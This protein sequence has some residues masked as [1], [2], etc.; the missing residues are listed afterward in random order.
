MIVVNNSYIIM[1]TGGG[2]DFDSDPITVTFGP[3]VRRVD[4]QVPL[5]RDAVIENEERFQLRLMIPSTN[6]FIRLGSINTAIGRIEDSTGMS[7][8]YFL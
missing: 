8:N 5:T 1:C 2:V 6:S 3:S 7:L 4:V